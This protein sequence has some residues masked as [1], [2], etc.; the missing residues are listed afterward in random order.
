MNNAIIK[1]GRQSFKICEVCKREFGPLD[2]LSLRFCSRVC[3]FKGR[4]NCGKKG[5]HYPHLWRARVGKC[6]ICGKKYRAVFDFKERRQKYC[7]K[8]CWAMRHPPLIGKC[9]YCSKS[10]STYERQKKYCSIVCRDA[11][12]NSYVRKKRNPSIDWKHGVPGYAGIHAWVERKLGR[13]LKCE[14]CGKSFKDTRDMHWA[15]ADHKYIKDIKYWIRLCVKCHRW[16]DKNA[17]N[18]EEIYATAQ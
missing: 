18:K 16:Y 9:I 13:P 4:S 17:N 6:V 15:N 12:P 1:K 5:K 3:G 7:S 11:D 10:F 14:H 2:R 8:K